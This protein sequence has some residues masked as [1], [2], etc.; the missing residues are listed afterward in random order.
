MKG[1][2]LTCVHSIPYSAFP[3]SVYN[4]WTHIHRAR[5]MEWLFPPFNMPISN[6]RRF[7]VFN[8]DNFTCQYCGKKPPEV[9]LQVDHIV[10]R[11]D[12]GG[13]DD[14]N[15]V[16]SCFACNNGKSATSVDIKRMKKASLKKE[17]KILAERKA[18]LEAY[19]DFLQQKKEIE[20]EEAN[21][22]QTCWVN[23]SE[24]EYRLNEKG[25]KD[26][27]NLST[28]YPS[29]MIFEAIR[30]A[31]DKT[32]ISSD[33]KF[34]YMCGILKNMKIQQENPHRAHELHEMNIV[35]QNARARFT[36]FNER[37]IRFH[38]KNIPLGVFSEMVEEAKN[39]SQLK[40]FI[41]SYCEHAED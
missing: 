28:K 38:L 19:Y 9:V 36:Y 13:D 21:I 30:I 14:M 2:V 4:R 31:W 1:N 35:I 3:C 22:Y 40:S 8:R 18:Q 16:T 20:E 7:A 17:L 34:S 5:C 15:L 11:K 10:S 41:L 25:L 6:K 26:M 24:G 33:A 29:E 27:K 12:G 39:W 37:F 23:A 32:H